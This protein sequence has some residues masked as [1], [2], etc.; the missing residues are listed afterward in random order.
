MIYPKSALE[1]DCKSISVN[2][3]P[4]TGSENWLKVLRKK[5]KRQ[6]LEANESRT[7]PRKEK[8][9]LGNWVRVYHAL[10]PLSST[11]FL[12]GPMS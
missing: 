4:I 9:K 2:T 6:A 12:S 10:N 8:G 5:E 11:K 7:P 3:K 1:Q